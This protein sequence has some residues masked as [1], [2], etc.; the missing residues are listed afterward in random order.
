MAKFSIDRIIAAELKNGKYRFEGIDSDGVSHLIR[1]AGN[2]TKGVVQVQ[3][4]SDDIR[5][6]FTFNVQA[7]GYAGTTVVNVFKPGNG[8]DVVPC[9]AQ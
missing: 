2:L 8:I 6:H 5:D 1:K 7:I 4:D 3:S 9:E